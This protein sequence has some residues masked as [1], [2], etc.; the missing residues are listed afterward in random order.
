MA[1]L[2]QA[3]EHEADHGEAEE[4]RNRGG[5]AFEVPHQTAISA[6]PREGSFHDPSLWQD[7]EPVE[8]GSLDDF[9]FPGAGS[10]HNLRHF[11]PLISGIGEDPLDEWKTPP[12][13]AQQIAGAV[14]VLDVGGQNTHAEEQAERIDEDVTLAPR[15][16]LARV[17]TLR[18]ERGAPF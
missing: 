3:L 8:V 13:L 16:F 6:D 18:V 17:I 10:A 14:A 7:D 4:G 5:I 9:E 15:A 11:R 12:R 2:G 1:W